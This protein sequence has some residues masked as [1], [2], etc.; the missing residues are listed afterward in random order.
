M[1]LTH[2][3]VELGC[4]RPERENEKGLCFQRPCL[5]A[6][7]RIDQQLIEFNVGAI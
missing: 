7:I 1:S 6:Y 5:L 3:D 4:D 2:A